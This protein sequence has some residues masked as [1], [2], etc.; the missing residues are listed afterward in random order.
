METRSALSPQRSSGPPAMEHAL[1]VP[2]R[3]HHQAHLP[4]RKQFAW[5]FLDSVDW[6]YAARPEDS[7]KTRAAASLGLWEQRVESRAHSSLTHQG[8]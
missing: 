2:K 8:P 5:R 7:R 3:F 6:A 4:V 1:L